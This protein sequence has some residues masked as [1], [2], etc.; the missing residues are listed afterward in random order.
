MKLVGEVEVKEMIYQFDNFLLKFK[1]RFKLLV[2]HHI[3]YIRI[4]RKQLRI[5]LRNLPGVKTAP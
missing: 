5:Y 1:S 2:M 3:L 4:K